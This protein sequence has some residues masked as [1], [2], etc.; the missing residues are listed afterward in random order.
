MKIGHTDAA[1]W[2]L[3]YDLEDINKAKTYVKDLITMWKSWKM[4]GKRAD[5]ALKTHQVEV[6]GCTIRRKLWLQLLA[7]I[8][9]RK[10]NGKTLPAL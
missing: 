2:L 4:P 9:A 1:E 3:M 5:L 8:L 6:T 7:I 10:A